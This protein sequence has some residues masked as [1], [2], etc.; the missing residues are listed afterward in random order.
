[1]FQN[2][3]YCENTSH[4]SYRKASSSATDVNCG[5]SGSLKFIK[6]EVNY[7]NTVNTQLISNSK[8]YL[9]LESEI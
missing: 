4:Y 2:L 1:M 9:S 3:T 7:T 5:P 8:K 6:F